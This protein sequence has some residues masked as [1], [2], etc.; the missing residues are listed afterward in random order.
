MTQ[1]PTPAIVELHNLTFGYGERVVLHDVSLRVP[2]GKI[3][4]LIGPMGAGK[5]T[6]LRLIGGQHRAQSGEVLF[7][8]QDVARMDQKQLYA[9]RRRM[10]MLFQFGALFADISVLENVAF[11]LREHTSLPEA[12]IRDIVL[13]KLHAVGLRGARDLMPSDLSGGMTRRV[14][15]ARAIALDPDLVIYDEPFSG[16]DPISL[17]TVAQ[18]IRQLNDSLSLSSIFVSHEIEQTFEIADHVIVMA[19][20]KVVAEGSPDEMRN[21]SDPMVH[22]Y[23]NSL[24][25]GPV[26]FHYPRVPIEQDLGLAIKPGSARAD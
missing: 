18:L 17:H 23:V 21:S 13:M 6:T 9:M 26:G 16:L 8:G 12:L 10:G 1:N 4:A 22:Q 7:E 15:L 14:A 2:R 5:T 25:D 24:P 3:T 20:G 11:P 19:E